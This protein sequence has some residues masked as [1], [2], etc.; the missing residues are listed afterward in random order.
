MIKKYIQAPLPFQG[1]KRNFLKSFISAISTE[2]SDKKI[3]IDLFGG[4]GLLSHTVKYI[5]PDAKVIFNDYDNYCHRL[6]E[7]P[8]TNALLSEVRAVIKDPQRS[9]NKITGTQRQQ[10]LQIIDKYHNS[11]Y[12]DFLTLSSSLLFSCKFIDNYE[13]FKKQRFYNMLKKEDYSAD[14]YLHGVEVAQEDFKE[15]VNK[16]KSFKDVCFIF[17]PPYLSTDCTSYQTNWSKSD[18]L[19]VLLS[20]E[21]T[22]YF[23]FTSDKT[24]IVELL[25]WLALHPNWHNPLHE[26]KAKRQQVGMAKEKNYTDIMFYKNLGGGQNPILTLF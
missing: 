22:S 20:L 5:R 12:V 26:A 4:S 23:Y 6:Q 14:G 2:F 10:I 13:D 21:N 1:Q 3:F 24:F 7:I 16:Y 15:L 11:G 18:Y 25:E 19:D 17:D 9:Q 8:R